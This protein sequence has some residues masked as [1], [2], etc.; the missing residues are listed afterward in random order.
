MENA[1]LT[2]VDIECVRTLAECDMSI[3]ETA[4]RMYM[5]RTTIVYHLK[6]V[7]K[8][9]GLNPMKFRDLVRLMEMLGGEEN[10]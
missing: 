5:A 3:A 2:E 10:E 4:R 8:Y 6:K 9:T 1:R 7:K